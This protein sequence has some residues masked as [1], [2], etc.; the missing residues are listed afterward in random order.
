MAQ[1]FLSA[2]RP[3][4]DMFKAALSPERA[5]FLPELFRSFG[6]VDECA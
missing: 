3:F 1:E 5:D 4:H 6:G 2:A